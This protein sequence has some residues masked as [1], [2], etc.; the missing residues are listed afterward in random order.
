M[1]ETTHGFSRKVLDRALTIDFDVFFPNKLPA[2]FDQDIKSVAFS[3][4]VLSDVSKDRLP[5]TDSDGAMSIAFLERIN[6]VLDG[7]PFK[8]AYR[9]LNELLLMITCME[10]TT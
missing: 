4:P 3:Y 9:T 10:P 5:E 6:S 8:V 1:D 2:I 7:T